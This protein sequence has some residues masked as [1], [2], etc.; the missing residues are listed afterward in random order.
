MS[1]NSFR[2]VP[3]LLVVA[4][5]LLAAP[6]VLA[7]PQG[8]GPVQSF[9]LS[10]AQDGYLLGPGDRL[11]ISVLG[12]PEFSSEQPVLPDGTVSVYLVGTVPV[13]NQTVADLSALL[14]RRLAAYIKKPKVSISVQAL[15]PL[16]I[17]VS[18]EVLQP[19][20][21]QLQSLLATGSIP[22]VNAN[23]LPTVSA[24]LAAAGGV[25]NR[26]DVSAIRLE[27]RTVDGQVIVKKIDLWRLMNEG[28]VEEDML[29]K[30]GDVLLVPQVAADSPIDS[31]VIGYSTI[32][33]TKIRVRVL[34]EVNKVGPFDLDAHSTVF[35][36]IAAAGGMT[37]YAAPESVEVLSLQRDGRVKNR[38]VNGNLAFNNDASQN[39]QLQ[40]QDAVIVRR[41]LGGE[42]LN[43]L[44]TVAAPVS[45]FA[46]LFFIFRNF[47]Y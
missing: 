17:A 37:N 47:R 45:T 5:L 18:G 6:P 26:A 34:G 20:P 33:P 19:G 41:S 43:G 21:R 4:P 30:D 29:L 42:L 3:S 46:N 32:A 7:Q 14:E 1:R 10:A 28:R 36:A 22:N 13:T 15:R 2:A 27:R 31:R 16:R 25:T 12:S 39:L 35:D 8:A 24:A 11:K 23:T 38:I 40:D 44:N 9:D